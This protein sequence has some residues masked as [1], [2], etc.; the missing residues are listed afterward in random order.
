MILLEIVRPNEVQLQLIN[1]S[2]HQFCERYFIESNNIRQ[3]THTRYW[4]E[5]IRIDM[6]LYSDNKE[7]KRLKWKIRRDNFKLYTPFIILSILY[8]VV[9]INYILYYLLK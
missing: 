9:A 8:V 4:D 6:R 5:Q 2:Y 1:H 7:L 3:L